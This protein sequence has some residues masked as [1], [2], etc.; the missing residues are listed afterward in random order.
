MN[1]ELVLPAVVRPPE[2]KQRDVVVV[3]GCSSG[4]GKAIAERL[5]RS[6]SVYGGSRRH[7]DPHAWRYCT[8][9]VT[10]QPSISRFVDHV[11]GSEGRIDTLITSAGV[12]LAGAVEDT[13]DEEAMREFDVNVFGCH[14]LIRAVLPG[15]RRRGAGKVIVIGSIGGLIGLPFAPFYS[16]SKFA[17]SGLVEALRGEVGQFGVEVTIV[18]PGDLN[19]EFGRHRVLARRAR[20]GSPYKAIFER[21]LRFYADQENAGPSPDALA[22]TIARLIARQ[23][24]PP[25]VIHGSVLERL[26]VVGKAVLPS[27]V[28]EIVVRMAYGP[29]Q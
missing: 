8:L 23:R 24:L 3:A 1:D 4:I 28:F 25:R 29:R 21:A 27:R 14:R 26:G 2:T 6:H 15:M 18:H 19:T 22:E 10:D 13:S 16:A 5:S 20:S 9:D 17:L 11:V 12:G 7:C